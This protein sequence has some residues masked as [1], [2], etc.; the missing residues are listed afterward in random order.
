MKKQCHVSGDHLP[1]EVTTQDGSQAGVDVHCQPGDP[2]GTGSPAPASSP[3]QGERGLRSRRGESPPHW[4]ACRGGH[5][6]R[7]LQ[8]HT[9]VEIREC[10]LVWT[11]QRHADLP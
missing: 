9:R 1:Q 3:P 2:Q 10:R 6:L 7:E 11:P 4:P 8:D 5:L